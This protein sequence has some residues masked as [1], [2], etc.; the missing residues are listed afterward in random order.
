MNVH[1]QLIYVR[2]V[3]AGLPAIDQEAVKLAAVELREFIARTND[4]GKIAMAL[5][6]A[7]LEVG[8]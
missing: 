4:H 2:G 1:E 5:V 7:E 8:D 3:V 6:V